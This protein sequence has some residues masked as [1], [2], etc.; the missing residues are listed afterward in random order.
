VKRRALLTT[1]G[2]ITTA[3]AGCLDDGFREDASVRAVR[4]D[5]GGATVVSATDL[6]PDELEIARTAVKEEFYHACPELPEALRQFA[7]RFAEADADH[8]AFRG[9]TYAMWI[10]IQD[11]GTA[12]AAS[13]P[14]DLPSCG[15]L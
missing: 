4:G 7:E 15:F 5:A 9:T 10:Q 2:A 8:M 12:S 3:S 13:P 11:Y 6:P 14:D 1:A